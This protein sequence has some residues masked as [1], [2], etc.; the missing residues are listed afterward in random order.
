MAA[1]RIS[2]PDR[3]PIV[4]RTAEGNEYREMLGRANVG[5]VYDAL[6]NHRAVSG[7]EAELQ[8]HLGLAGKSD[9]A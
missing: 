1:L 3:T 9:T 6:L 4:N 8:Q 5:N 2:E 7:A